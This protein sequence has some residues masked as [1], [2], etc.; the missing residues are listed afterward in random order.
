MFGLIPALK[1]AEFVRFGVMHR[2]TFVNAPAVLN[3]YYQVKS[4]SNIFIAGQLSGVEGY[5]ESVASGLY[6]AIN[7]ANY[8]NNKPFITFDA[9]TAIGAMPN[10]IAHSSVKNFQPM[11]INWRIIDELKEDIKDKKI[12]RAKLAEK[13]L[14]SLKETIKKG[15]K[16]W[17]NL[18]E[19]Q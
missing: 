18:E 6:A 4:H 15:E 3:K 1:N 7:M 16:R 12:K 5:I 8:L 9:S 13:A 11:N 17:N 10:Y 19:Q 14:N 2:N